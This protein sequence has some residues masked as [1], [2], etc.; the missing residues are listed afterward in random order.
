[1][2]EGTGPLSRALLVCVVVLGALLGGTAVVAAQSDSVSLVKDDG[3]VTV[4]PTENATIQGTSD[5]PAGENLS[6]RIRS[7]GETQPRFLKT[8]TV[9]VGEDGNFSATFDFGHHSTNATF[10]VTV[11]DGSKTVAEAEGEVVSEPETTTTDDS[12]ES[13]V[14]GFGVV[15]AVGALVALTAGVLFVGRR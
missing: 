2:F 1:M 3:T 15:A 8:D 14:P 4:Y 6:I 12:T 7:T 10:A 5:L 13:L 9:T 11:V